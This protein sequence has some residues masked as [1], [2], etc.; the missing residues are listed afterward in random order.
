MVLVACCPEPPPPAPAVDV[1]AEELAIRGLSARWLEAAKARD[2][3]AIDAVMRADATTIFDGQ[4]LVGL[5]AIQANREKEWAE[6]TG[7]AIEWTTTNVVVAA[8]GD[9][10]VERGRWTETEADDGEVETGEYVTVWTKVD[11]Q[12]KVL[13][14]AGTELE[15]GDEDEDEDEAGDDD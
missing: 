7:G 5:P 12:W 14:D 11:G 2:G 15:D 10:A 8:S 6:E 4:V 1:A 9:L 3:A 13:V